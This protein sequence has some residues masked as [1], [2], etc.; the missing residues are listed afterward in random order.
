[1]VRDGGTAV[2]GGIYKI[3]SNN[4]ESRVPGLGNLPII[5][6]LFKNKTRSEVNDE[7][8]IFVT[9]RIIKI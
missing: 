2:I 5:G 7:L 4:G 3:T 8:L 1:V 9:A 6:Y